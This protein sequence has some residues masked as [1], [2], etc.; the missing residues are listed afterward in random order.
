[1]TSRT[2]SSSTWRFLSTMA[3]ASWQ[4]DGLYQSCPHTKL[5]RKCSTTASTSLWRT[6]F[7]PDLLCDNFYS[8]DTVL[9]HGAGKC[10]PLRL[11][12][13]WARLDNKQAVL[14]ISMSS[15][16]LPTRAPFGSYHKRIFCKC[17]CRGAHTLQPILDAVAWVFRVLA[18]VCG[19][20]LITTE[21][22]GLSTRGGT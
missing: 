10:F 3:V 12:M 7:Q 16:F 18:T 5:S 4:H 22:R 13:D 1:M 2:T 6:W 15:L 17:G 11:F 14:N 9:A 19:P 21:I 20:R 8:H